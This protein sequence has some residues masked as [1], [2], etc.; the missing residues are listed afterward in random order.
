MVA[1]DC[2]HCSM[3][4]S[5]DE[6]VLAQFWDQYQGKLNCNNQNCGQE[7]ILPTTEEASA[8]LAGAAMGAQPASPEPQPPVENPQPGSAAPEVAPV[9]T[10]EPSAA[11]PAAPVVGTE[12]GT[13][14]KKAPE[15]T[16]KDIKVGFHGSKGESLEESAKAIKHKAV[17][18]FRHSDCQK[19]GKDTFDETVSKFLRELE[20]EDVIS[21]TPVQYSEG[22]DKPSDYGV[23]IVHKK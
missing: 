4:L 1:F 15:G 3:A 11:P 10:A 22:K 7:I 20:D 6:I 17:K 14:L 18:T 19:D 13:E 16:E 9:P 5:L 23:I 8:L 2:P 12:E 21:V